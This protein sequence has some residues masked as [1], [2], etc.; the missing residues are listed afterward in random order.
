[1]IIGRCV[2]ENSL[3]DVHFVS[4]E[5][6]KVW[7][8]VSLKYDGKIILG[9]I[10][11]LIRGSVSLNGDIY[12]PN[13]IEKIREIEGKDYYI[14]GNIRILGDVDDNL[15][16]PRT[17]APPGTE[18]QVANEEILRKIFK[19]DNGLKIGNL[20]SQEDVEVKL[21]INNMVSRHLAILAMTGAGKSNTVSVL[22]DGLLEYNGC[23]LIFDM[24]GEYVNAEFKN[25]AVNPIDPII[26]PKI[27]RAHV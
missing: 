23:I 27:G 3:I 12:D 8:Y 17:P 26:N 21:N 13:T 7:E 2:G 11:S 25:G 10:E 4:K 5:M 9:M 14:K 15:R 6:P 16:I 22:I 20:I 1:M 19:L 24:H 18:I